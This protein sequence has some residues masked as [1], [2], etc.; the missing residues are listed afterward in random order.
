[1][2]VISRKDKPPLVLI[3]DGDKEVVK[4]LRAYLT[5]EGFRTSE[6]YDGIRGVLHALND[7]P[8]L[9]IT[10]LNLARLSGYELIKRLQ[11]VSRRTAQMPVL[12]LSA[13]ALSAQEQTGLVELEPNV[14]EFVP[15]P[16]THGAFMVK[17]HKILGTGLSEK[18][19][20]EKLEMPR[21]LSAGEKSIG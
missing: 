14:V 21:H 13:K 1:M 10:E 3:I 19:V 6:A 12:I 17:I 15:K 16:V 5:D 11:T 20:L 9:I 4:L 2:A 8:D 18:E 7:N